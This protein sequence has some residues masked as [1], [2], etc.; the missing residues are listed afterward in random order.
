MR[1]GAD[2][3]R[4]C[5]RESNSGAGPK[6]ACLGASW[7]PEKF[8]WRQKFIRGRCLAHASYNKKT[9]QAVFLLYEAWSKCLKHL[10][11]R[12]E[13]RRYIFLSELRWVSERKGGTRR[14]EPCGKD[15]SAGKYFCIKNSSPKSQIFSC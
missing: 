9:A 5:V 14:C 10:R 7:C 13:R 15:F 6:Q 3:G 11:A 4:V 12:I 2:S 8:L 1:R